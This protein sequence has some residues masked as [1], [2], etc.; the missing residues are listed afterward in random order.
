MSE[1][2]KEKIQKLREKY[3]NSD[4]SQLYIDDLETELRKLIEEKEITKNP[5]FQAIFKDAEKKLNDINA[6]LMNDSKL[7]DIE[8][9]GLFKQKE[10]WK[11]IF[12]R[13]GLEPHN[14]AIALL[15]QT[16]DAKLEQ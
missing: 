10:V 8:R 3:L 12:D 13:F 1:E 4:S 2:Q 9:F 14:N 6:L 7:T 16:I 15:E 11:F 5:I